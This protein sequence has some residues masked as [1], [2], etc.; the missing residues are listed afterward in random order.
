LSINPSGD[1][2]S[3]GGSVLVI[4]DDP[5]VRDVVG[6][7]LAGLGYSVCA[8][9]NVDEGV[10]KL[11]SGQAFDVVL[12]DIVMPETS[13]IELLS[14]VRRW[15]PRTPVVLMTGKAYGLE[16]AVD[17]G[18]IPLLKPFTRDQLQTVLADALRGRE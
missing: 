17:G 10:G 2:V 13:G 9:A 5:D 15:R 16:S 3:A 7:M 8:C 6:A 1:A 18:L 12:A 4:E 14:L 11:S